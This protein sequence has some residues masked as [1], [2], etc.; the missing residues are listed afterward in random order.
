[1]DWEVLCI[2]L[3][4]DNIRHRS[5]ETM[6]IIILNLNNSTINES[7]GL[8]KRYIPKDERSKIFSYT[9]FGRGSYIQNNIFQDFSKEWTEE[10]SPYFTD[11]CLPVLFS[12]FRLFFCLIIFVIT[13]FVN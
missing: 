1:M 3:R 2:A 4:L 13:Y 8:V 7:A 11:E 5:E 6:T 9:Y 12:I 10:N